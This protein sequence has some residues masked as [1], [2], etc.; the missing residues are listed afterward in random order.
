MTRISWDGSDRPY[1]EGISQGMLYPQ[2]SPGV[3]WNGLISVSEGGDPETTPL[4]MDGIR[5]RS[6]SVPDAFSGT[7]NAFMYPDEFEPYNGNLG[8]VTGQPRDSFGLSYRSNRE[9]HIVYNATAAPS[10]DSY[11]SINASPTPVSFSWAFTTV[12]VDIPGGRPSAHIVV[13]VDDA[14]AGALSDLEDLIYGDD[15]NDPSLPMPVDVYALF[16][17]YATLTIVDNGDG[18]WTATGPDDAITMLDDTTFQIDW[19]S[20]IFLDSGTYT[21]YSL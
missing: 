10:S 16:E 15:A 14:P 9:L 5:Y 2:N 7:I 6:R 11:S 1:D 21:I 12:P 19:P 13:M 4:Y 18:T 3:A 20:A 17:S 8:P